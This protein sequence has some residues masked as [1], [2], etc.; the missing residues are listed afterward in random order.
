MDARGSRTAPPDRQVPLT[1]PGAKRRTLGRRIWMVVQIV[2][3]PAIAIGVFVGIL[4]RIAD[5]GRVWDI[6]TG[7]SAAEVAVLVLLAAWNLVTYWPMLVAA[8]PGLTLGQAAV[9]CQTSTTVAMTVPAGGALAVGV[10]Y[11]MYA[12]W[13]FGVSQVA[14]SAMATFVANMSFK[15]L[16][17]ALSLAALAATGDANGEGLPAALA[18]LAVFLTA[19]V[20]LAVALRSESF[21]RRAGDLAGRIVGRLLRL[22]GKAPV[23][24]WGESAVRFRGQVVG[25]LRTRGWMLAAAELV[26]QLSVYLVLLASVRFTGTPGSA[27]SWSEVLAVFAFVR[28]VTA[29]PIIP[30]NVGLAELGYIGGLVLAGGSRPEVVAAVLAFRFLTFFAQIPIGGVTYLIWLRKTGWRR[31]PGSRQ[32]HAERTEPS[33]D[34]SPDAGEHERHPAEHAGRVREHQRD[35][36]EPRPVEHA[37]PGH[38]QQTH[39]AAAEQHQ[40]RSPVG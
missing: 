1:T 11:G 28:L 39:V 13:G 4:P 2:A 32:E 8:M 38:D 22:I 25:L 21:A 36:R 17:P 12:S 16:L 5:L 10:S 23:A 30:G 9:V 15:L 40:E 19:F 3:F 31:P 27:V 33:G 18:G 6:V 34:A 35:E 37:Q 29:M 20:L 14:L 26:S 24:G 7:M